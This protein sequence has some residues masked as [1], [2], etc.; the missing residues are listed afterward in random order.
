MLMYYLSWYEI[1]QVGYLTYAIQEPSYFEE[2]I[3]YLVI[4]SDLAVLI[5]S[6]MG[7][8]NIKDVVSSLTDKPVQVINTSCNWENVGGNCL[9]D[10]ILIPSYYSEFRKPWYFQERG[11]T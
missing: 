2:T 6:G 1:R 11:G 7:V 5:N 9:F 4:G 3:S 10:D 8:G